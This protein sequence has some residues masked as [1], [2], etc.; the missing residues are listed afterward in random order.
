MV[1][2]QH[3]EVIPKMSLWRAS[4]RLQLIHADICGPI[5]PESHS[6]KRYLINFIDDYC[7]YQIFDPCFDKFSEKKTKNS[8]KTMKIQKNTFLIYLHRF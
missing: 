4:Q 5:K 2:K 6:H 1:G 7:C 3:R 8:K